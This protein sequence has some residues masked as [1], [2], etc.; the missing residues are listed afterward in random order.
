MKIL[1]CIVLLAGSLLV[2]YKEEVR[3]KDKFNEGGS[4]NVEV[5]YVDSLLGMPRLE[6]R[7]KK[8]SAVIFS[9]EIN[10]T[11]EAGDCEFFFY[12]DEKNN[13]LD[14]CVNTGGPEW[15]WSKKGKLD[16]VEMVSTQPSPH[17]ENYKTHSRLRD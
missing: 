4:Y 11:C 15:R 10:K 6:L 7:H 9:K 2:F 5:F 16:W 14:V 17:N 12:F 1:F 3:L 8:G 13:V